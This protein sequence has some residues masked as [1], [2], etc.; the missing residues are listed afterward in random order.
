MLE[1]FER[2]SADFARSEMDVESLSAASAMVVLEE[3]IWKG[4]REY[5][6]LSVIEYHVRV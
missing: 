5:E 3:T 2:S 4:E 6:T 1:T